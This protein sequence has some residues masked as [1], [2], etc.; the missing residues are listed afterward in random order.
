MS[1]L[2]YRNFRLLILTIILIFAWGFSAFQTLPRMEDPELV[3]RNA[4]VKTFLPGAK[5]ERIESLITDKIEQE[6]SEIEEI[7][8]YASTSRTGSSIIQ[9]E[10]LPRVNKGE[11]DGIWSRVRDAIDDVRVDLP[12]GTTEPEFEEVE[13]K[14]YGLITALIWE[15]DDQPNYA[16]LN[17][18][19][20]SLS[21]EL[22]GLP[23]TEKV[24][25]FGDPEEEILVAINPQDLAPLNLTAQELS[26]QIQQ[27]DA[28]V[29]AGQLRS[30]DH[31]L[32]IEVETELDSL[33]RIRNIPINFGAN[34]Q[35]VRL[36]DIAL[37]TKGI[38]EPPTELAI[39]NGRPAVALASFVESGY[40]IDTW[41]SNAQ[42]K[43]K[44]F[45]QQLPTGIKLQ[46]IF[47]QSQYVET[48]LNSLMS[49]L[50]FG[51]LLVFAVTLL[52]M[53]W[54]SALIVGITL[55]LS[56]LMV[57][58]FMSLLGIPLHQISVTGIIVALGLL[59][60]TAIVVVDEVN[61]NL[62]NGI[63]RKAAITKTVGYLKIPLF[64]STLTTALAFMPIVLMPGNDGEFAG[65][66]GISV[67]AAV[68]S[69][70]FLALTII[71]ALA[72][73]LYPSEKSNSRIAN[74][75]SSWW[76][77]GICVPKL[78][79][80]YH[81]LLN[82]V[83]PRPLIGVILALIVPIFGFVQAGNL[84][85]QFFPAAD[86]DQ[87]QIEMELSA[88]SSLEQ[89][90]MLI[91]Q[92]REIILEHSEIIDVHWFI[93]Q[94]APRFYYNLTGGREQEANYAQAL[95]QLDSVVK[96][97]LIQKI[98]GEM[99]IAFPNAQIL[100]RALEQGP[101]FEA[102]I[103][104]RIYGS[105]L[106]QLQE[107]G[108][109]ARNILMG[110]NSVTHTRD[111]ISQVLPQLKLNIDEEEARLAGLD[112]N[113]IAQQLDKIL[114]GDLGGSILESTEE[115][116]VRVRL[117]NSNRSNLEQ[118]SSLDLLPSLPSSNSGNSNNNPQ[119]INAIP[120]SAV[121][122][123]ALT[124]EQGKITR[125]NGQ[126]VN[127]V[128]GFITAG[129]LPAGILGQFQQ[130]LDNDFELPTGY[131]LEFGGEAEE[132]DDAVGGLAASMGLLLV[133]MV[134]TLVLSL[135]S[136][137][138]AGIIGIVAFCSFGLGLF[139]LGLFDYPLGFM[140]I[141][142]IIGLVGVAINDSIVVLIALREQP[143]TAKGNYKAV[144]SVVIHQT[145]HVITTTLTTMIGFVP[146]LLDSGDFWP[147]LAV[148]I[149]GGISGATLLALF[150]V[151]CTYMLLARRSSKK[152]KPTEY[153]AVEL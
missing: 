52:M 48:R 133:L 4:I 122:K 57:F 77:T 12:P 112:N 117:S 66:I 138:L 147:P 103:E 98:Q 19:A 119:Q 33:E 26:Q 16:I 65:T 86:R 142:G 74:S 56:I 13:V 46:V 44:Q 85:E 143:A 90:K 101:P 116:P 78:T 53:G 7:K 84:A 59:I 39:I 118:I 141:V 79:Q 113:S 58:G 89:T 149:S 102:P 6:L 96:P 41:A 108:A 14:A 51:V 110:I 91:Q 71:P 61:H 111:S 76:Q 3:S 34:D 136:F 36:G 121:G 105:D 82:L 23:G 139:S 120:L 24:E 114:E 123:V 88:S 73:R 42:K 137:R 124:P 127:I 83:F 60:D 32:L 130:H 92:A 2:F 54:R 43:L 63:N 129:T 126:R 140:A 27:S 152:L 50:L 148:A 115:I 25:I 10:L 146:L 128:Q 70:L 145:R 135:S 95:V 40:R 107:L 131:Q 99:D 132:R 29:A 109:R 38:A 20:E 97:T 104:M 5:A 106:E 31:D 8:T 1:S 49:N 21:D 68:F 69:S 17:R 151:P 94:N 62:S 35:F 87:F 81:W 9:L 93:G 45:S 55:P 134:A 72:V 153:I 18:Q 28:K 47:N 37:V 30:S 125:R 22:Q 144:R 150:F 67:I 75:K 11:V 80:L 15:Q 100:V 64:S